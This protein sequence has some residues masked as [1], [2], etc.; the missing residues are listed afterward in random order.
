MKLN[1]REQGEKQGKE[2]ESVQ[3]SGQQAED[4][5]VSCVPLPKNVL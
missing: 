1:C 4:S 3:E 2:G 5:Y